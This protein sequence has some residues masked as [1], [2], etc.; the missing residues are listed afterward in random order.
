MQSFRKQI[1]ESFFNP[2][3]HFI[4]LLLFLLI[5]DS[6]GSSIALA[7]VYFVVVAILVYSFLLYF[8]IYKYLGVSYLVSTLIIAIII[9]FPEN[10]ITES[11]NPVFSEF[12]TLLSFMLILLLRKTITRF[13][14]EVT[15][16]H[17]TM[18]N[19][20]DEHFRIVWLLTI[21]LFVYTHLYIIS[22]LLFNAEKY[23]LEYITQVYWG[24]LFFVIFY[25]F[26][27]V[28]LIRIRLFK[29]EWWPIVNENG[30]LI[31]SIQSQ[32]SLSG[33]EKY[34]HPIVRGILIND[35]KVFLQKR[36]QNDRKDAYL[37]D[38]ALS[39]HIR[40][41]ETVEQ[42]IDRTSYDNYGV[43]DLKPLLLSKHIQESDSKNQFIYLF[44]LCNLK[45]VDINPELI[46]CVKWW[47]IQQIEDNIESGIFTENFVKEF[48][49]LKRSGLLENG[50]YN[51]TCHLK[52]VVYQGISKSTTA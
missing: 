52:E 43:K 11:L 8:H 10:Y 45:I 38:V 47:T 21:I 12:V 34:I 35:S 23:F 27:R 18:T 33:S 2:L 42:C 32:E 37:W 28:T 24:V 6:F 19:N 4:P 7:M 1:N 9:F 30:K 36:S 50:T 25:E 46:D 48:D 13:V 5:D 44:L 41:N 31:G 49:I 51:C 16:K 14:S 22:T 17:I 15:P 3:L 39:N 40:M 20:L 29:E 26:I